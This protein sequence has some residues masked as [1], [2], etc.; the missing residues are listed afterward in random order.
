MNNMVAPN[1][2]CEMLFQT[3]TASRKHDALLPQAAIKT[4][5]SEVKALFE[6]E[7]LKSAEA[8]DFACELGKKLISAKN[9]LPKGKFKKFL[10]SA[11]IS[12]ATAYR[13][14]EIAAHWP[15]IQLE[16]STRCA[17]RT[18]TEALKVVDAINGKPNYDDCSV[19]RTKPA[20][21]SELERNLSILADYV[22]F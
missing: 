18:I 11:G 12:R 8:L 13:R 6:N 2:E 3:E 19:R 15:E 21:R 14:L 5:L 7:K 22:L 20:S 16:L 9:I 4:L 1:A 10:Q 17:N